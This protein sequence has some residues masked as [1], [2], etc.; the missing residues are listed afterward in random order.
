MKRI[1][2]LGALLA[3]ALVAFPVASAR[4]TA[5]DDVLIY[6]EYGGPTGLL[7]GMDSD[8]PTPRT[9]FYT[10][11]GTNPTHTGATPGSG[12]AVFTADIPIPYGSWRHFRALCY[13]AGYDDS[14]VTIED[15]SN[16]IQ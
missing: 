14:G 1:T 10:T 8:T 9:I 15:I 11:N 7:V 12:T 5:C 3:L 16:P 4:A 13:K 2:L 6:W